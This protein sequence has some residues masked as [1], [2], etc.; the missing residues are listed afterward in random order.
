MNGTGSGSRSGLEV[1][2]VSGSPDEHEEAALALAFAV[3]LRRAAANTADERPPVS[4]K[5][6]GARKPAVGFRPAHSW[7]A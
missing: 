1:R 6:T 7:R 5:R 2:V 4:W 3:V